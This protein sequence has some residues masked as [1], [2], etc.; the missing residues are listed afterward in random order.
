MRQFWKRSPAVDAPRGTAKISALSP[1]DPIGVSVHPNCGGLDPNQ[2]EVAP[3]PAESFVDSMSGPQ[4]IH[5]RMR[6]G[7]RYRIDSALTRDSIDLLAS[8]EI[9]NHGYG[10]GAVCHC[11]HRNLHVN[12]DPHSSGDRAAEIRGIIE[13][14]W[15]S[16]FAIGRLNAFLADAPLDI[17]AHPI[18]D[19]FGSNLADR[20]SQHRVDMGEWMILG[21]D[22]LAEKMRPERVA[23]HLQA[24]ADALFGETKA[25][26]ELGARIAYSWGSVQEAR[27]DRVETDRSAAISRA[28]L[29][30]DDA[31]RRTLSGAAMAE[32]SELTA[33]ISS[34]Q[35]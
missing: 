6:R 16:L 27:D 35:V 11:S 31:Q 28:E 14:P 33:R 34:R 8:A 13:L 18:S 15:L 29:I 19:E 24:P 3:F 25:L 5:Y 12:G 30:A 22:L 23:E 32:I 1:R 10:S 20:I 21:R 9:I 26:L 7:D 17:G 2:Y 4:N